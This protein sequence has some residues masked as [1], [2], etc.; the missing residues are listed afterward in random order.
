MCMSHMG[1]TCNRKLGAAPS[2]A[3]PHYLLGMVSKGK[4]KAKAKTNLKC[5]AKAHNTTKIKAADITK[6]KCAEKASPLDN[7]IVEKGLGKNGAQA[8]MDHLKA[9]AKKNPQKA[10]NIEHWKSLPKGDAKLDFAL[11]LKV[12][13]E[14]SFMTV[15]DSH[16]VSN[17]VGQEISQ[18]WI[19][20]DQ[21]AQKEGLDH[22]YDNPIQGQKLK[23]R[24]EGLP[25]RPHERNDLAA[26]N[27]KQYDYSQ[28]VKKMSQVSKDSML[29]SAEAE[30]ADGK[31][32]DTFAMQVQDTSLA[33]SSSFIQSKKVP[34]TLPNPPKELSKEEKQ[35]TDWIHD[36]KTLQRNLMSTGKVFLGLKVKG[37]QLNKDPQSG[38]TKELLNAL[39]SNYKQCQV[40]D[41]MVSQV[42]IKATALPASDIDYTK[43]AASI[44]KGKDLLSNCQELKNRGLRIIGK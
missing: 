14:C 28:K 22:Y 35:K 10:N 8:V 19:T 26:K 34:R 11:K 17:S 1:S 24:L 12:D 2:W 20:E 6:G 4:A 16:E 42:L 33:S 13:R 44:K 7:I 5:M 29:C 43:Y 36:V 3:H 38:V 32:F 25:S 40:L 30:I 9:L 31:D 18:W 27:Y 23:D 39:D 37:A 41:E 15:K 21:V